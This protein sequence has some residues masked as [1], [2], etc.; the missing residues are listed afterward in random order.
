MGLGSEFLHMSSTEHGLGHGLKAFVRA[1]LYHTF[2]ALAQNHGLSK[3][4]VQYQLAVGHV[5]SS[6]G[7]NILSQNV[8]PQ[9]RH[10]FNRRAYLARVR[11]IHINQGNSKAIGV[12]RSGEGSPIGQ[13]HVFVKPR[14]LSM[15]TT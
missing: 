2:S 4:K 6:S 13:D 3:V 14:A 11:V 5:W 7:Q 1:I 12:V 8:V 15:S 9:P 10:R